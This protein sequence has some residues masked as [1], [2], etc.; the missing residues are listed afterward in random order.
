M[1]AVFVI[2][3]VA[4]EGHQVDIHHRQTRHHERPQ[5]AHVNRGIDRIQHRNDQIFEV[6]IADYDLRIAR[7]S[8]HPRVSLPD[9]NDLHALLDVVRAAA[10]FV[11][12][13]F[14]QTVNTIGQTAMRFV[15]D[16][17]RIETPEIGLD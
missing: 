11:V 4:V 8:D 5:R 1:I 17:T 10:R 15:V 7:A 9:R 13:P 2:A 16:T 6:G 12:V 14:T 3:V